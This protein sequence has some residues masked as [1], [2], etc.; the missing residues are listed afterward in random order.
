MTL[1]PLIENSI[2]HGLKIKE[3][4]KGKVTIRANQDG[5]DLIIIMADSGTG[6]TLDQIDEMNASISQYDETFGYGVRNVNKRIEILY[7]DGYGLRYSCNE[8]GGV[9]VR[10]RLPLEQEIQYK[11][12]L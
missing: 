5:E 4:K 12:V 8:Q 11:G 2:Y 9:T 1:Q 10:I 3:G 6:M 7:G